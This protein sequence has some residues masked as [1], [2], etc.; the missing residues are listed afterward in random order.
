MDNFLSRY[1][2]DHIILNKNKFRLLNKKGHIK[3]LYAKGWQKEH[4]FENVVILSKGLIA[5]SKRK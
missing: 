3:K 1:S 4:N 2:V 5:R